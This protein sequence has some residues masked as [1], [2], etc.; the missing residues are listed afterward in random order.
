M[1]TRTPFT[2]LGTA[3]VTPFTDWTTYVA[4]TATHGSGGS[5]HGRV[6]PQSGT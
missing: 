1:A 4:L 5:M 2:G 3:L 6:V